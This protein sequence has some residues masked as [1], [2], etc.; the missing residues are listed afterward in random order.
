MKAPSWEGDVHWA[1]KA[2]QG[3]AQT[4][5]PTQQRDLGSLDTSGSVKLGEPRPGRDL[6]TLRAGRTGICDSQ[7][8]G[9]VTQNPAA[10]AQ[11]PQ[12]SEAEGQ[13]GQL[14]ARVPSGPGHHA[15]STCEQTK[16]SSLCSPPCSPPRRFWC[17]LS[18][19]P[20]F[21]AAGRSLCWLGPLN[22]S[23]TLLS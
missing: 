9:T 10:G 19:Q 15:P 2:A 11:T 7:S 13:T 16:P 14:A 6:S 4:T 5:T 12:D 3:Q 21:S 8:A 20:R 22:C 23:K 17:P 1:Q 18:R